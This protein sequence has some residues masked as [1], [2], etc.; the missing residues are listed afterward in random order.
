[1]RKNNEN[2]LFT[3]ILRKFFLEVEGNYVKLRSIT[4]LSESFS[5]VIWARVGWLYAP[6]WIL[7]NR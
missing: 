5:A 1:M 7:Q 2:L 6:F 3:I 4:V